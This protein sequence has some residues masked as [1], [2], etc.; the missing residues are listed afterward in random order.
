MI[1]IFR[2]PFLFDH[3]LDFQ[4]F[5]RIHPLVILVGAFGPSVCSKTDFLNKWNV[6]TNSQFKDWNEWDNMAILGGSVVA[7]LLPLPSE[8]AASRA[9]A[10]EYFHEKAYPE[11]NFET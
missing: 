2:K 11:V 10:A 7:S 6:F 8:Y 3:L 5:C 1:F 9:K 4:V